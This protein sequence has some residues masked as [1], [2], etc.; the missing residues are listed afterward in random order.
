VTGLPVYLFVEDDTAQH[1]VLERLV[2]QH[3]MAVNLV[4]AVDVPSAEKCL[5]D[6]VVYA[7]FILD[8]RL[9][10]G[11][12]G[13]EL[14]T[15]IRQIPRYSRTKA[16]VIT[17]N[18]SFD[19]INPVY[20]DTSAEFFL[21]PFEWA[22]LERFF[23]KPS[24]D[25]GE[26]VRTEVDASSQAGVD[27]PTDPPARTCLD[28]SIAELR[29]LRSMAQTIETRFDAA[30]IL[31][32][33]KAMPRVYGKRAIYLAS[34]ALDEPAPTLYRHAK[35]AER[36]TRAGLQEFVERCRRVGREVSWTHIVALGRVPAGLQRAEVMNHFLREGP[37]SSELE[38]LV[39]R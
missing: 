28:D 1:R 37:A 21:K 19:M 38:A 9:P 29:R 7:G 39:T 31:A 3:G 15:T 8:Q 13:L 2:R 24:I 22:R 35:V 23:L 34:R 36:W 10:D 6:P 18:P 16:V 25:G 4:T 17:G 12:S 14:L 26:P 33:M 30:V 11:G 32:R 5:A 20:D 27:P